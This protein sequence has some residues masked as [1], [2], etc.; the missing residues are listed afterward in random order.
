MCMH[1]T[2]NVWGVEMA[3]NGS[4]KK[5]SV[6]T[7]DEYQTHLVEGGVLTY[8]DWLV[9]NYP[10]HDIP[11]EASDVTIPSIIATWIELGVA[12][13]PFKYLFSVAGDQ[14]K[15]E[16]EMM[17]KNVAI[18]R[19]IDDEIASELARRARDDELA[20]ARASSLART[21]LAGEIVEEISAG[22]SDT[23]VQTGTTSTPTGK[24]E[25]KKTKKKTRRTS[26][27]WHRVPH[28]DE[29]KDPDDDAKD[30][31]H[32]IYALC[33]MIG[34]HQWQPS[35][36]N[37]VSIQREGTPKDQLPKYAASLT[38]YFPCDEYEAIKAE[39]LCIAKDLVLGGDGQAA[40]ALLRLSEAFTFAICMHQYKA[41]A[42]LLTSMR[43]S[44]QRTWNVSDL[45]KDLASY[46]QYTR[47]AD[48]DFQAAGR[49]AGAMVSAMQHISHGHVVPAK[50]PNALDE[51]ERLIETER[52]PV[53]DAKRLASNLGMFLPPR[54]LDGVMG[55]VL[56]HKNKL[57]P[58]NVPSAQELAW[59]DHGMSH[60]D[61][62]QHSARH[63]DYVQGIKL[64]ADGMRSALSVAM[65]YATL[66]FIAPALREPS[67]DDASSVVQ[68]NTDRIWFAMNAAI[69]GASRFHDKRLDFPPPLEGFVMRITNETEAGIASIWRYCAKTQF[70]IGAL[71]QKF[72]CM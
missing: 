30:A 53:I 67:Q 50:N 1:E 57:S 20:R 51:L 5:V 21:S 23:S 42:M 8:Y 11:K 37:V 56:F 27:K 43:K 70:E 15:E 14:Y 18:S 7:L 33:V 4:S 63:L 47:D 41:K 64:D 13:R 38:R 39:P 54:V 71:Y 46:R 60:N 9:L 17:T 36:E 2:S 44:E 24:E 25:K 34:G 31:L 45:R 29:L 72:I 48:A 59:S 66:P 28:A 10:D 65:L 19:R 35:L 62:L 58:S 68:Y 61:F 69:H 32:S 40:V 22:T 12:D 3:T 6:R 26:A 55:D 49:Y 52:S 16:A